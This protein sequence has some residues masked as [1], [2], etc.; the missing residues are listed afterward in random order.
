MPAGGAFARELGGY[1]LRKRRKQEGGIRVAAHLRY[2]SNT[3]MTSL[4]V[5]VECQGL[6]IR[7]EDT[8]RR[9]ARGEGGEWECEEEGGEESYMWYCRPN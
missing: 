2:S 6:D 1:Q 8:V 9:G 5:F 3:P 4:A 7:E